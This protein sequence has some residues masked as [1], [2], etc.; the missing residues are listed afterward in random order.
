MY[1]ICKFAKQFRV[2]EQI[3]RMHVKSMIHANTVAYAYQQI[4]VHCVNAEILNTRE[5]IVNVTKHHQKPHFVVQNFYHMIWVKRVVNQL[6]VL[7]MQ[8]HYIFAHV[9]Q[10]DYYFIQVCY[11]I[12]INFYFIPYTYIPFRNNLIVY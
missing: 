11:M 4:Q 5:R 3:S 7:K 1:N 9:N 6:L 8:Y 10:M 2:Y 12:E